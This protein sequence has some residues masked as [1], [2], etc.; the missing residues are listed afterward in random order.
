MSLGEAE[1]EA[2][3]QFY[4]QIAQ[5]AKSRGVV[6]S[7][8]SIEGTECKLENLGQVAEVT[9]GNVNKVN[10]LQLTENFQSVLEKPIIATNV[11][12]MII[13]LNSSQLIHKINSHDATTQ[14]NV[15]PKRRDSNKR[16]DQ[17]GENESSECLIS[18]QPT[19]SLGA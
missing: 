13:S 4:V 16:S 12:G 15:F 8:I 2:T 1:I 6:V 3:E 9:G 11:Q 19:N 18:P 7:V 14:P 10:P 5:F 17:R